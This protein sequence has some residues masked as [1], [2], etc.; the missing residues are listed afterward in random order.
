MLMKKLTLH[1]AFVY[2]H[3]NQPENPSTGKAQK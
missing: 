3:E 1:K 2:A